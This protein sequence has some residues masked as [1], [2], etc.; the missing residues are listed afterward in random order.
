MYLW[1]KPATQ[2]TGSPEV[3][4]DQIANK[5]LLKHLDPQHK[6]ARLFSSSISITTCSHVHVTCNDLPEQTNPKSEL[7]AVLPYKTAGRFITLFWLNPLARSTLSIPSRQVGDDGH[8]TVST[9]REFKPV[10]NSFAV[11]FFSF[12]LNP[13]TPSIYRCLVNDS[14]VR[15]G[16]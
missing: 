11:L 14:I 4:F 1:R 9:S 12:W 16:R 8:W 2:S 6:S 10:I 7:W 5:I 3:K 13:L 15:V